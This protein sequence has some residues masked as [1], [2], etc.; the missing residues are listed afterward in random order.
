MGIFLYYFKFKAYINNF[1]IY[2]YQKSLHNILQYK[3][4]WL[5]LILEGDTWKLNFDDKWASPSLHLHLDNF[6]L[7]LMITKKKCGNKLVSIWH[8]NLLLH[9]SSNC[10]IIL[11]WYKEDQLSTWKKQKHARQPANSLQ[12][13]SSSAPIITSV[14]QCY[15]EHLQTRVS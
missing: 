2:S 5:G 4:L 10:F 6:L 13:S 1:V 9:T 11:I 14:T 12:K 3:H 15:N 8:I 7:A